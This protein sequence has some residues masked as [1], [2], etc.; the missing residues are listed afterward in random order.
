MR[1]NF[2]LASVVALACAA[3]GAPLPAFAEGGAALAGA[4]AY[5]D[6]RS[7]APGVRRKLTPAD[8][9]APMASKP[10][11]NYSQ[12]VARPAGA[13]PKVPPGFSVALFAK[14]LNEPRVVRVAP[15]GDIFVAESAAGRVRVLRADASG[16]APAKSE[17]FASGLDRPFGVAF[18][19][20]G[21]NPAY[22]YVAT[23]A[24]VVRYPYRSGALNPSGPPETV[25]PSLP[26]GRGHWTRDIAFSADGET[27][28]VS[29]GSGSNIGQ[30]MRPIYGAE[31]ASFEETHAL[32]AAWGPEENRADVLA[33]DPDGRNQ[34]VFAAGI[35]NCSGLTVQPENG[36]LWCAVNERDAMGDD[37][38]PDFAT[39]VRQGAFYGWPW[40]YI[41]AN[42]DP[43]RKGERP[44]LAGKVAVPDVLIQPHSAPLGITFYE[45]AQFP[46]DYKGDAFVALHG[47]WNRAKRTG[48]KVVRLLFKNGEP[49]GEYEDFLVGFVADDENVWG[50]PVDVAV[51][52]DGALLVTDDDGGAIWRVVYKRP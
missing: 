11:A 18:Y 4:A 52:R 47:S 12:L 44:D 28:F 14:G 42:E 24:Q 43:R 27:M 31:L 21:P 26:S 15:N 6:W 37:L 29:V 41:G 9:P 5:G 48:Y 49:T 39:R 2:V 32:G 7:D 23:T 38:P 50:R 10:S 46:A 51:A 36:A 22:V 35:R 45:A 30:E 33:F 19:P 17:I 34:R 40:Y 8:M 16:S 20:P 3:G 13:S 1:G 25:V